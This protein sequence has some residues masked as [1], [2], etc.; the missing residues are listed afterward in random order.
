[1]KLPQHATAPV[2]V[3]A[4]FWRS[5]PFTR[6]RFTQRMF[7]PGRFSRKSRTAFS[8][9]RYLSSCFG[10]R[11]RPALAASEAAYRRRRRASWRCLERMGGRRTP[12]S[13]APFRGCGCCHDSGGRACGLWLE[14]V[15]RLSF[16]LF[17]AL[18]CCLAWPTGRLASG[19]DRGLC[20]FVVAGN[21][22]SV[23]RDG[24]FFEC[25][26]SLGPW[27]T[28]AAASRYLSACLMFGVLYAWTMFSNNRKRAWFVA[29]QRSRIAGNWLR[30]PDH[31]AGTPFPGTGYSPKDTAHSAGFLPSCCF[32]L[33][34][35]VAQSRFGRTVSNR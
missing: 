11:A 16:P 10:K 29:A 32:V 14:V 4:L 18:C 25:Q 2:A 33:L 17:S 3:A 9:F 8:H 20:S 27:P 15:C 7:A 1:M 6:Q 22:H 21:G 35:G 13:F 12:R 34:G 26:A 5:W 24:A 30:V 19:I 23:H 31:R 28:S